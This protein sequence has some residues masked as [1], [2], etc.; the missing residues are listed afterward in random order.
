MIDVFS[1]RVGVCVVWSVV[2]VFVIR[3]GW[4]RIWVLVWCSMVG[5]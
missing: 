5:V 2:V 3:F 4:F 1:I